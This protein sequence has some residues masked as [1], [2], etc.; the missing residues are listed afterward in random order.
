ME[1]FCFGIL[2]GVVLTLSFIMIL[3]LFDDKREEEYLETE[4]ELLVTELN[5]L[6]TIAGLS[7]EDK[8]VI[9]KAL[10]YIMGKE[11]KK[12]IGDNK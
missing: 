6:K 8:R 1:M 3:V 2:G 12:V 10:G 4:F 5:N 7:R 9:D 11:L